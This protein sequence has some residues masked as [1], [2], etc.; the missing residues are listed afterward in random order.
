MAKKKDTI[1]FEKSL[2]TL[3]KLV[4]SMETGDLSLEQSL[5]AFEKG[6]KLTKDCQVALS[7]AEQR[8]QILIEEHGEESLEPFEPEE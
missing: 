6:I 2:K 3:E 1:D 5:T 7:Q 4:D 8:V